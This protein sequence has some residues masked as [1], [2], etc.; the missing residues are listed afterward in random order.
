[1]QLLGFGTIGKILLTSPIVINV[2]T[3]TSLAV[4]TKDLLFLR[5]AYLNNK[6]NVY[7]QTSSLYFSAKKTLTKMLK[8]ITNGL[9]VQL[10]SFCV[11]N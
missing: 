9:D 3:R 8:S 10:N 7:K 6:N 11:K 2:P 1:M 5:L 4:E